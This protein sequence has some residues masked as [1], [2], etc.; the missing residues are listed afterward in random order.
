MQLSEDNAQYT[1]CLLQ[2]VYYVYDV[3]ICMMLVISCLYIY[4]IYI[5]FCICYV[6]CMV[7]RVLSVFCHCFWDSKK[8]E[9]ISAIPMTSSRLP[10]LLLIPVICLFLR[11][12]WQPDPKALMKESH[13]IQNGCSHCKCCDAAV[14]WDVVNTERFYV[15]L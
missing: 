2:Y 5:V 15:L 8:L 13:E 14:F 11:P 4:N 10:L 3:S 7:Y 6:R 12:V 9:Q 1:V